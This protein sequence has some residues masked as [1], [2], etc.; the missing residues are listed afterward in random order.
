MESLGIKTRKKRAERLKKYLAKKELLNTGLRPKISEDDVIFPIL[1]LPSLKERLWILAGA[2]SL[3]V[4]KIDFEGTGKKPRSLKE[5]LKE[6]LSEREFGQLITSFNIVGKAA[7]IEIPDSL[8]KKEKAIGE[9]LLEV[10]KNVEGV[11][12]ISAPHEGEFRVQPVTLIAGKKVEKAIYKE[13]GC[14]FE[15]EIGKVFFSPRLSSERMRIS[16]LI[17][18]GEVIGALFAGVGPY[19]I[20]FAKHSKMGK[21]Y[22]VELNPAAAKLMEKNVKL[23]KVS[24]KIEVFEGD[25]KKVVPKHLAGKCDRVVMPLPRGGENFLEEAFICLK[26]E[27]GVIHFYAFVEKDDP[28]TKPLEKIHFVAKKLGRKV[29]ILRKEKVRSFSPSKIQV[30]MDFNVY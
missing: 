16:K 7:I 18:K 29:K 11:Y 14:S 17:K 3:S 9:A 30:V 15:V 20:I 8:L 26:P 13:S 10:N 23:N 24:E 4:I 1:R 25:V 27:G 5:A 2:K 28:Y 6:K 19:P 22:A 21:A 12:K